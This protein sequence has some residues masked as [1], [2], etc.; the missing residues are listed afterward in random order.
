[1]R[2]DWWIAEQDCTYFSVSEVLIH[3]EKSVERMRF[4]LTMHDAQLGRLYLVYSLPA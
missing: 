2:G 4:S 3:V 1:M